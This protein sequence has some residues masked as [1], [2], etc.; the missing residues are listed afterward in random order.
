[1][2]DT[3]PSVDEDVLIR[4]ELLKG[5][6]LTG[7]ET[8]DNRILLQA[9]HLLRGKMSSLKPL[10]PLLFSLKGEPLTLSNHYPFEV[11]YRTRVPRRTLFKTGRQV[12]KTVR[13][14]GLQKV[15]LANGRRVTGETLQV[16]DRVI[17]ADSSLKAVIGTVIDTIRVPSK[18]TLRIKTRLGFTLDVAETHP[19]YTTAGWRRSRELNRGDCVAV[20]RQGGEFTDKP[21]QR[22]HI[23]R[24]ANN[25]CD[26]EHVKT[27]ARIPDWVFDLSEKNTCLFL[28]RLWSLATE[29]AKPKPKI[30]Y[31][32]PSR[33][34]AFDVR[35]LLLKFGIPA[36]VKANKVDV[37]C[38]DRYT[39]RVETRDGRQQFLRLFN[40]TDKPSGDH[41]TVTVLWD[42]IESIESGGDQSCWDIEVDT[43][44]N[45]TLDGVLSHNSTTLAARGIA[46]SA[47]VPFFSTLYVTPLFETVRRFSQN[48]VRPLIEQSPVKSL[49]VSN[50]QNHS[51][52]Q[53]TFRNNSQMIFSFAFDS[54]DRVRGVSADKVS[55]DE[56]QDIDKDFLSVINE[57]MSGSKYGGI[58]EYAGT[59]K[60][61]EN[62][63]QVLWRGSSQAEWVI[64]CVRCGYYNVPALSHDLDRMIGPW[65]E[66]I[67]PDNPGIICAACQQQRSVFP[68]HGRWIHNYP[69]K[70]WIFAGY[71]VPQI[72]M[73]MH[74]FNAEKWQT[75]L[76]KRAGM[77]N[78]PVNVFYN[79]VCGESYDTGSR[80]ITET[81]L[82]A[83]SKD[84]W[85]N[86]TY[87]SNA[88]PHLDE[89]L[90][91]CLAVDWGG[92]GVDEMSYTCLAVLGWK[93]N[94][95]ID[96]IWGHRSL[97]PHDHEGEAALCLSAIRKFK[98]H[99]MAHDY[100]GAGSLRETFIIQAGFP[101]DRVINVAYV[102]A[103]ATARVMVVKP[104]TKLNPRGYYQVD[105]ARSL[106][107]TCNQIKTGWLRFFNWDYLNDDNPGL[108][109]D[110]L[111]L[112]DEKV[113]S[114]MGKDIYTIIRDPNMRDDFAQAVNIGCCSLWN[115]TDKWPEIAAVSA[116][117]L[118]QD[119]LNAIQPVDIEVA[120]DW[121]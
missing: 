95:Q 82:R 43:Y 15:L 71:H 98:C 5:L 73:P 93:P 27:D 17:S 28:S 104:P 49:L 113:D 31:C 92:G 66:D 47:I 29:N 12:A 9:A 78:T 22:D 57:C 72:V 4:P 77:N 99:V 7:H 25:L 58:E 14:N 42:K 24:A 16:G 38:S 69:E 18:P 106:L 109:Y 8:Y 67:G 120:D 90:Y 55:Y 85:Q 13:I 51:V 3:S 40:P 107:L 56:S 54:P 44:H 75:L 60:S 79:E 45:Y 100:T 11:F 119:V 83:A 87:G 65:H 62:T 52:F 26:G 23:V 117:R 37:C 39:V 48:Y 86:D 64:K 76:Q 121:V 30:T 114:R 84:L 50:K 63:M 46:H 35:A 115:M 91:R 88:V 41:G 33:D 6:K 20:L 110:F 105:K 21:V 59:P 70:R 68:Q 97:T 1:M 112:V 102:R 116:L 19:L 96:V 10:L 61:M 2:R 103:A 118:E 101:F 34:L 81:E 53:R 108:I 32:T 80:I 36:S 111:G 89:Y 74:C 94:G